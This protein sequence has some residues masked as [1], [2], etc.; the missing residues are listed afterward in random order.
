MS[1]DNIE[2]I[3]DPV[4]Q[5]VWD[6]AVNINVGFAQNVQKF[7]FHKYKLS[8]HLTN[9]QSSD[10]H[11]TPNNNKALL[12]QSNHLDNLAQNIDL[13]YKNSIDKLKT[14]RAK[15][16]ENPRI[17]IMLSTAI[18]NLKSIKAYAEYHGSTPASLKKAI[19]N[20]PPEEPVAQQPNDP[21]PAQ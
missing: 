7:E 4:E 20:L 16:K 12:K 19:L 8:L 6:E 18:D 10:S 17:D 15:H 1:D 3:T 11:N 2:D 13:E 9:N 5:E 14:L 21:S